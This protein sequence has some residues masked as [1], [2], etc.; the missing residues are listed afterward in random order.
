MTLKETMCEIEKQGLNDF[1]VLSCEIIKH[2]TSNINVCVNE[3]E[4]KTDLIINIKINA[5]E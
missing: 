5:Y 1:E 3:E 2:K 4:S